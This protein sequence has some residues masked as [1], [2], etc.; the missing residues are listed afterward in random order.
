M[1]PSPSTLDQKVDSILTLV[2][3]T[4]D[5]AQLYYRSCVFLCRERFAIETKIEPDLLLS[6]R[7][8]LLSTLPYKNLDGQ[9][10]DTAPV[11]TVPAKRSISILEVECLNG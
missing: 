5:Q 9:S 2:S 10:V 8:E 4:C 3:V 7:M 1:L 6:V 11:L